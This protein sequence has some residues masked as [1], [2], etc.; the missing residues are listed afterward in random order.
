VSINS[1][2]ENG[3]PVHHRS[4]ILL[5]HLDP[6]VHCDGFKIIRP[7]GFELKALP[8]SVRK[9]HSLVPHRYRNHEGDDDVIHGDSSACMRHICMIPLASSWLWFVWL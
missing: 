9:S 5:M 7:D 2:K 1:E 8:N 4:I 3:N 6:R